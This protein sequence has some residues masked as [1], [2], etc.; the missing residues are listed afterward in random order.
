M[1][2]LLFHAFR[3]A[4]VACLLGLITSAVTYAQ[5]QYA[6]LV[7]VS[8][9]PY[10]SEDARLDLGS[11]DDPTK[12]GPANDVLAMKA[13]LMQRG[14]DPENIL[15]LADGISGTILPTRDNIIEAFRATSAKL[16]PGN[17]DYVFVFLAGH[18]SQQPAVIDASASSEPDG[19]DEVFLPYDVKPWDDQNRR[20]P[21]A[22]LDNEIGSL[23]ATLRNKG[24]FVWMVADTCHSATLTRASLGQEVKFRALDLVPG[25]YTSTRNIDANAESSAQT[26]LELIAPVELSADAGGFIGFFAAQAHQS[27]P[28]ARLPLKSEEQKTQGWFTYAFNAVV[29]E[30]PNLT[31]GQLSQRILDTYNAEFISRF[32]TPY[33]EGTDALQRVAIF[34][35]TSKDAQ[36]QWQVRKDFDG[37]LLLAAGMLHGVGEGSELALFKTASASED[38]FLG[39]VTVTQAKTTE[40]VVE[41]SL[42][43]NVSEQTEERLPA[44]A[45]ARL[46][47]H[48]PVIRL[49]VSFETAGEGGTDS[50]AIVQDVLLDIETTDKIISLVQ[51]GQPSDVTIRLGSERLEFLVA[52]EAEMGTPAFRKAIKDISNA[53]VFS[54]QQKAELQRS[55]RDR[56]GKIYKATLLMHVF[57]QAVQDDPLDGVELQMTLCGDGAQNC[58]DFEEMQKSSGMS[59]PD[60]KPGDTLS[61][62]VKNTEVELVDYTVLYID[63]D[64]SITTVSQGRLT[65]S[66]IYQTIME[67]AVTSDAIGSQQLVAILVKGR[68]GEETT[69]FAF[70]EEPRPFQWDGIS[71]YETRGSRGG[72]S[73]VAERSMLSVYQWQ[74]D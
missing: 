49:N 59:V 39:Y 71:E 29:A 72:N 58:V 63:S 10:L 50:A 61:L 7:G 53:T 21:N 67:G 15:V 55:V 24:A 60:L 64:F 30:E 51:A 22:L 3:R 66:E 62:S 46:V 1:K 31:Y 69:N 34:E 74:T 36:P 48:K 33:F 54:E 19:M 68:A 13:T 4:V 11:E 9:Y 41:R 43:E 20:L 2:A 16:T 70:L 38:T 35:N 56:L 57:N 8:G 17:G 32:V 14:F 5:E 42:S 28:Q 26:T 52:G 73:D 18:G 40:A 44:R 23:L 47:D 25:S 12:D 6:I 27:A 45:W 37:N 65:K